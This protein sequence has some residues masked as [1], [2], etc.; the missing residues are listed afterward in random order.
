MTVFGLSSMLR[1]FSCCGFA[2]SPHVVLLL[3]CYLFF[4]VLCFRCSCCIAI[5]LC[6]YFLLLIFM[7]PF[8]ESYALMLF[9]CVL[10][11]HLFEKESPLCEGCFKFTCILVFLFSFFFRRLVYI[12]YYGTSLSYSLAFPGRN[13]DTLILNPYKP[14]VLLWD[15]G[16]ACKPR[17]P[18]LIRFSTVC[19]QNVLLK[20]EQK[21]EKHHLKR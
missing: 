2:S 7:G 18:R 1:F 9:P 15:I 10:S 3:V 12:Y 21:T 6:C 8:V 20:L 14:S 16:K 5:L 4:V 19:V 13:I 11:N 17:M